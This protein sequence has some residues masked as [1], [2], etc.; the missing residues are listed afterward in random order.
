MISTIQI[1]EW[2]LNIILDCKLQTLVCGPPPPQKKFPI[3][4]LLLDMVITSVYSTVV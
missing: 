2:I 4:I 3:P 1:L